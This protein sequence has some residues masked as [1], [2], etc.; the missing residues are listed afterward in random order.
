MDFEHYTQKAQLPVITT[1]SLYL[2]SIAERT[3]PFSPYHPLVYNRDVSR[4]YTDDGV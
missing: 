2:K 1:D 3:K 4:V